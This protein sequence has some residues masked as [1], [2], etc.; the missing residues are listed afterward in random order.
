ML[1]SLV[2]WW[3]GAGWLEAMRDIRN[4]VLG[5]SLAFSI[6]ILLR[7]MFAPWRRITTLPDRSLDTKMRA[8]LDNFISRLVGF[9]VRLGV[10]FSALVIAIVTFAFFTLIALAWPL[11]PLIAVYSLV[12]TVMG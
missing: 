7:T 6:P 1:F 3:Y 9:F 5:I 2:T 10:I 8:L 12:R 11:V 4:R